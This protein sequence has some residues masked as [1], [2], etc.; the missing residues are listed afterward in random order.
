[1]SFSAP[2]WLLFL[3]L[4][5]LVIV[6]HALSVRW[7]STPI[8]SLVFWNEVLKDRKASLRIRRLLTSLLLLLQCLAMTAMA[9]ALGGPLIAGLGRGADQDVILVVDATAS[10]QV[11]EGNRTRWDLAREHALALAAGLRGG[12]RMAVVLAEKQ[13]HVLSPF[14]ADRA[15]LRRLIQ[16]ARPS[17]EP[18]DIA[19]SVLF[20]LSLRDPRRGG[21]VVVET[22]GAFPDLPG[23][24]T[25]LPWLRVDLVG[26]ARDNVGITQMA[27]RLSPGSG[28][29]YQLFL[30]LRNAGSAPVT[31]PLV[32]RAG[33][34]DIIRRPVD[35]APGGR[36]AV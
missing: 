16:S 5:P 35:V 25:T 28:A 19:T 27:F 23:V 34:K 24:D 13:P 33:G 30:A 17:D 11:E 3:F 9:V 29:G 4:V 10:M 21:Q 31:V 12:A 8:S 14:T 22:D 2:W 1:M 6:L 7:R 20:A 26:S 36:S 15:A 18:G 32:V